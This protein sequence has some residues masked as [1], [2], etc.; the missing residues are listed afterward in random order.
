MVDWLGRDG[1]DSSTI[2]LALLPSSLVPR[3]VASGL[4]VVNIVSV[5]GLNHRNYHYVLF[6]TI[7]IL[8]MVVGRRWG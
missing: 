7:P 6:P 2:E 8:V 4:S 3:L 1:V 5:A